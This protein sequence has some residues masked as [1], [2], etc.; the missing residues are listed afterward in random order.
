MI[1]EYG[2]YSSGGSITKFFSEFCKRQPEVI[3]WLYS[4][5]KFITVNGKHTSTNARYNDYKNKCRSEEEYHQD[6]MTYNQLAARFSL[7]IKQS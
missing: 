7:P 6:I 2:Y 3:K 5:I 1:K 4:R